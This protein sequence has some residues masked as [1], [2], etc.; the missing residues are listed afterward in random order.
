MV[1]M[2]WFTSGAALYRIKWESN[3]GYFRRSLTSAC[4]GHLTKAPGAV[5]ESVE[6]GPRG[7][8]FGSQLSQTR[9]I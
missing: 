9:E 2:A 7:R 6:R 3:L 8:D 4:K 1:L 5:A